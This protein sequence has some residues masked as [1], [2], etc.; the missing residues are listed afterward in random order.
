MQDTINE[1][2]RANSARVG[3]LRAVLVQIDE[4]IYQLAGAITDVDRHLDVLKRHTCKDGVE[5]LT[6][7]RTAIRH[8]F[9]VVSAQRLRVEKEIDASPEMAQ[10]R[11]NLAVLPKLQQ[12]LLSL[13]KGD[14]VAVIHDHHGD[15]TDLLHLIDHM[16]SGMFHNNAEPLATELGPDIKALIVS[17]KF[18]AAKITLTYRTCLFNP[19]NVPTRLDFMIHHSSVKINDQVSNYPF[20]G[21]H[22]NPTSS[23]PAY[24]TNLSWAT[25]HFG[26]Y[27]CAEI[28]STFP[29]AAYYL[30]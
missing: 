21:G 14:P 7:A 23:A 4:C 29:G 24:I 30:E 15:D 8:D 18:V 20:V 9:E 5:G 1:L 22:R 16:H 27:E 26:A 6:N 25:K 10:I 17:L 3:T 28:E 13:S 11:Y 12:A 2:I 19:S